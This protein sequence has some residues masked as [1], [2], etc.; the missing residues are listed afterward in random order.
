MYTHG[1]GVTLVI[2]TLYVDDILITGKDPTLVEQKKKELKERFEMTDM[3]EV[4]RILGMEVMRDFDEGTLAIIQTAY[5]DNV[6]ERFGM[7]KRER[8]AHFRIQ[9]RAISRR[10]NSRKDLR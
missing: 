6:L 1:S 8:R 5:L 7:Q 9:A 10:R 4:S 3:G 2:L